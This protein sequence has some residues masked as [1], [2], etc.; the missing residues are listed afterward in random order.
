MPELKWARVPDQYIR[1]L[2]VSCPTM[3]AYARNDGLRVLVSKDA[4]RWH[5][6]VSR[7]DRLPSW[8]ELV[9]CRYRFVPDEVYMVQCLPPRDFWVNEHEFCL[10]LFETQ[11]RGLIGIMTGEPSLIVAPG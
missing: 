11:D 7:N 5:L 3:E 4:G 10:H 2:L 1:E 8:L 6:S 9:E